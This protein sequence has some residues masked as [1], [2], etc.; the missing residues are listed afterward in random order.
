MTANMT[1]LIWVGILMFLLK[2][3]SRRQI[4]FNFSTP[5]FLHNFN[6][7]LGASINTRPD[8]GTLAYLLKRLNPDLLGKLRTRMIRWL[9]RKKCF[10]SSRLRGRYY[11]VAIDGTGMLVFNHRH[12]PH[13]LTKKLKNGKIIYYHM[14]LEAKLIVGDGMAFSIETEFIENPSEKFTVQDCELRAF[15]RLRKKLK[16]SF[17]QMNICLLLDS[18]YA[19]KPVIDICNQYHWAFLTVFKEGSARAVYQEY[20]ALRDLMPENVIYSKD[21][22]IKRQYR[23]VT[24]LDFGGQTVNTVECIEEKKDGE[25]TRFLWITNLN[26]NRHNCESLAKGG[27]KRWKIENQGFNIQK[28]GGY[29]LEHAFSEDLTAS[30]CLYFLLQI[31]QIINQLM[32]K[33][34]L[35]QP[36]LKSIGSLRNIARRLLE[37]L[38]K[39]LIDP[40]SFTEKFQIRFAP[41]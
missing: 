35:L 29:N 34:S 38:R 24:D 3:E 4:N 19:C 15:Y 12:C 40:G 20:E 37:S 9:I 23:G 6:L 21:H 2:L 22:G 8:H 13:C 27:R 36:Y 1:A 10:I 26:V 28:N 7:L 25:T 32:E 30:K 14:V 39:D 33:G 31:A 11:L 16:K 5:Q 41:P 17:P 18:L